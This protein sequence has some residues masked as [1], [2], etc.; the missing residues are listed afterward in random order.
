M[1]FGIN[2]FGIW[3]NVGNDPELG[4]QTRGLSAFDEIYADTRKWVKE[5]WLD[6]IA[7]QLYWHIGFE[8]A[9]YATLVAWWSQQIEGTRVQ[10][11]IGHGNYRAG[12]PGV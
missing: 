4:S 2:P 12:E 6:Y 10:L 11:W 1:K 9:D 5:Q 3:R 8:R 7:P